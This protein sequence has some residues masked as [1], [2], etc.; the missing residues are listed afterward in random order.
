MQSTSASLLIAPDFNKSEYIH[1]TPPSAGW[2]HLSFAARR[3]AKGAT[4][5]FETQENELALVVLG[6]TC[7]VTSNAGA[8]EE[9]G[10]RPN[11]FA[12]MPYT[13]YLPPETRFTLETAGKELDIAYGW[14][15]AQETYPARFV[16][17]A[18]V[19]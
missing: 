7:R 19:E 14:A 18:E 16:W 6:G 17:P 8:W 3:M 11:V 9:I 1:I 4:W 13:L 2:D 5:E 15:I 12:G 10:R